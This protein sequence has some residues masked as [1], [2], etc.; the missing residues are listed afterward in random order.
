MAGQNPIEP[1]TYGW[2]YQNLTLEVFP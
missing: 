2:L 1:P